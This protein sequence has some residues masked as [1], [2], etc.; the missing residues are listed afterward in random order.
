MHQGCPTNAIL[1][2]SQP[3][4]MNKTVDGGKGKIMLHCSKITS[5]DKNQV[6]INGR[7]G[8]RG[9]GLECRGGAGITA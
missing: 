8:I 1:N 2:E 3:S 4:G 9:V 7:F 6:L 5:F